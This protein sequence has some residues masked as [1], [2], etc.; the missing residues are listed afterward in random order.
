MIINS[1]R[2]VLMSFSSETKEKLCKTE[3]G[4]VNCAVAELTGAIMFGGGIKD[5]CIKFATENEKVAQRILKDIFVG[6]GITATVDNV[7]KVQR[8]NIDDVY[9]VE[10][11]IGGISQECDI[12]FS[13]CRASYVR[14]AFFGGGSVTTPQKS[15]HMEFD[16]KNREQAERLQEILSVDGFNSKITYRKGYHVVYI[17]GSEE[18]AD[19][20]G[21]M[22]AAQGAF[23]LFSVQIEKEMRNDVNRRVNCENA[24]TNKAAKASSK[25]LFAIKK[26]RNA[27]QWD[28]LPEVLKEIA[29]LR[30]EYPEDSLKELGEKTNPPIGKSGVNH[31][32]TRITQIAEEL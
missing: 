3:Y 2:V 25:H 13:C 30:E 12:P 27:K 5:D 29:A 31:R 9:Q 8:I 24:N 1:E 19:I 32:L 16:T 17:K 21:Y 6:F 26:I 7:S 4:C 14:G 10:N 18:I 23:E 22:G 28:R 20:L 11:I 15:Y